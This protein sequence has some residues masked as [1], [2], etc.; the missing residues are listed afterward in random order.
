MGTS[1]WNLLSTERATSP[2]KNS[3]NYINSPPEHALKVFSKQDLIWNL[4]SKPMRL[5][6]SLM[7]VVFEYL[8]CTTR[9]MNL[10]RK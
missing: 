5:L 6:K 10:S 8:C 4:K 2:E 7:E 1:N 3:K 9:G